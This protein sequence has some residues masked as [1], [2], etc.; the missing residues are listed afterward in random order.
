M[1]LS[2]ISVGLQHVCKPLMGSYERSKRS[3]LH[4]VCT[5]RCI[6]RKMDVKKNLSF[7]KKESVSN[8]SKHMFKRY[9]KCTQNI[10][11]IQTTL[12]EELT[13]QSMHQQ[14]FFTRRSRRKMANLK[15]PVSVSKIIL[16][17]QTSSCTSSRPV[18]SA[19]ESKA[20]MKALRGVDYTK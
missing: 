11:E 9:V 3:W 8:I 12:K 15:N 1:V 13:T 18:T 20:S 19:K 4:N 2:T 10:E 7:C 6:L 14:P 16:Q 5:I 17:H